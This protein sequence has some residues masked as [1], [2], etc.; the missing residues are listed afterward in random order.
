VNLEICFPVLLVLEC[1]VHWFEDAENWSASC[2]KSAWIHTEVTCNRSR[3]CYCGWV[4]GVVEC[5]LA[6]YS[7][8]TGKWE[9]PKPVKVGQS[10]P[11]SCQCINHL[12]PINDELMDEPQLSWHWPSHCQSCKS[13]K[14]EL[15]TIGG[16]DRAILPS[17]PS[18]TVW[19]CVPPL[20]WMRHLKE[21]FFE[22]YT[23]RPGTQLEKCFLSIH[24]M[25]KPSVWCAGCCWF[26]LAHL[27]EDAVRTLD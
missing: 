9:D 12:K 23:L 14:Y 20:G 8:A 22:P 10:E 18:L 1:I 11:S 27:F 24:V 5:H 3:V 17:W 13:C 6:E 21:E 26:I 16:Y 2:L 4:L 7:F 15:R 25:L 19:T